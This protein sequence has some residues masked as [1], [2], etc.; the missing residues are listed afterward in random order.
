MLSPRKENPRCPRLISSWVKSAGADILIDLGSFGFDE[1]ELLR[2]E[3]VEVVVGVPFV[4][5]EEL[6]LL[7]EEEDVEEGEDVEMVIREVPVLGRMVSRVSISKGRSA[8]SLFSV[9]ILSMN[10]GGSSACLGIESS[11]SASKGVGRGTPR[12][13]G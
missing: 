13:I 9:K 4:P 1:L 5:T 6:T 10:L 11:S 2:E 12:G 8:S 3:L 7:E